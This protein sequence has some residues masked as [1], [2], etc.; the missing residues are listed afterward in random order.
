MVNWAST[1][2][3]AASLIWGLSIPGSHLHRPTA[4][5]AWASVR[6]MD[7]R[8]EMNWTM[9]RRASVDRGGGSAA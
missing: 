2:E 7:L 1:I 5:G 6:K 8:I 4:P 9:Q 3:I